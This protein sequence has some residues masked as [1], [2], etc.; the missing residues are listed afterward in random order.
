MN[1]LVVGGGIAGITAAYVLSRG[2]SVTL[3]ERNGYV[4]GH[5][6]TRTVCDPLMPELPV[7]T[8][9]IV[10]NARNYPNFYRFLD[11][12]GVERQDSDMSFGY[13]CE[14]TGL[15]YVGPL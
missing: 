2:H 8:G 10:C 11:Q 5:T 7:D 14:K 3:L 15:Q 12:L 9:F 13:F 1:I 4:G 6:N